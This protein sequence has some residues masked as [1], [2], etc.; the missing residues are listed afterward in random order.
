MDK[1]IN[2]LICIVYLIVCSNGIGQ[3]VGKSASKYIIPK[4]NGRI[5]LAYK[6]FD[7]FLDSDR[8]WET[9]QTNFLNAYPEMQIVHNSQLKWGAIDSVLSSPRSPWG[10]ISGCS[11]VRF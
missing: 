7:D 3:K 10:C 9:Y 11:C 4:E 8:T 2:L 5:I 6:A 1:I